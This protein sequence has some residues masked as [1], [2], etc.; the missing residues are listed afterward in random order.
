MMLMTFMG[1]AICP[2][3]AYSQTSWSAPRPSLFACSAPPSARGDRKRAENVDSASSVGLRIDN[4]TIV[5]PRDG[6]MT[7]NM[8]VLVAMGRIVDVVETAAMRRDPAVQEIDGTGKFI[9]PGFNDM[10]SHVLE[11]KDPSGALAL[12]LAEGVTGFRQMSGS[13]ELLQK[14][15]HNVLPIGKEAPA[16]LETPGTILTPF[17]AGTSEAVTAEIQQ[18]KAQGADF[19][20][21]GLVNPEVFF[22]AIEEA[23][24][25][26]IPILGHL[27]EGTNPIDASQAGFKCIEHLGPGS[28][29]MVGCS[30]IEP[31]LRAD[32][33]RRPIINASIFKFPLLKR[34]V[35]SRFRRRLVN[36]AAFANP[37]GVALLQRALDTYSED[38]GRFLAE[39]FVAD[40]SWQVPTL[41]RLRT[42]QLADLPE[43]ENHASIRFMP[44]KSVSTWREVTNKFKSLPREMRETFHKAYP[45]QL[46]ITK[47]FSDVGVRM[48]TGTDGGPLWTPGLTLQ[49]EFLELAKAGIPPLEVLQ[50]TTVNPA[51]YLGR[52]DEMG[53]VESGQN[54]DLVLLEANPLD[55]VEN[56]SK[57]VGVVRAGSYYS[58]QD[59]NELK[60]R[61]ASGRGYLQ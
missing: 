9:V 39:R 52:T 19:I 55:T 36:P 22:T 8:S 40:G 5:D 12:M 41:V 16:L 34:F 58:I 1:S 28:T 37:A 4:A 38:K 44:P 31:E 59:L 53:L 23:K 32:S 13:P 61:V 18:Q 14:R 54:A 48:M 26:G 3:C 57:I 20:K 21:V 29:V 43:Y 51:E 60:R 6:S 46:A 10:H 33:S 7:A 25:V 49:E 27:Q 15:R 56:L 11:L 42:Q 50:M 24:R 35:M 47:L 2:C 45:R 30:T 17:N